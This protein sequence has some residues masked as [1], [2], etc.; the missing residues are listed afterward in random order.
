MDP[1]TV[2]AWTTGLAAII[3]AVGVVIRIVVYRPRLPVA[4]ELLEQID[5]MRTDVLALARWAHR[6]V[7]QAAAQ[8]FDL[9][10]PPEVFRSLGQREGERM[11][12]PGQHGWRAS[13][14]AQTGEQPVTPRRPPAPVGPDTQPERRQV[15]P[16]PPR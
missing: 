1:A 12:D 4:E 2:G 16:L 7:S 8:G 13:V 15:R 9:E 10:E 3:T 6:A 14:R 11:H 5:E